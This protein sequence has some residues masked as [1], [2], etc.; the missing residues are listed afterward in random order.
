MIKDRAHAAVIFGVMLAMLL[1]GVI[2]AIA[3]ET[4]PAR[5]MAGLA[6]ASGGNLEG[7]EVQARAG[8]LRDLGRHHDGHLQRLGQCDARQLPAAGRASCRWR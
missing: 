3:A 7:K 2:V 4:S 8:R 5:P 1:V 6:V